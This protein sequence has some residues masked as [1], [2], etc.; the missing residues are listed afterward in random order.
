MELTSPVS[1]GSE[2]VSGTAVLGVVM[3]PTVR[4][5]GRMPA[6]RRHILLRG[7][8]KY[9][10]IIFGFDGGTES[11]SRA[12]GASRSGDCIP[13]MSRITVSARL[14][15][16]AWLPSSAAPLPQFGY[17]LLYVLFR[18]LPCL[19][20]RASS[21]LRAMS[22]CRHGGPQRRRGPCGRC[23]RA[24]PTGREVVRPGAEGLGL[25]QQH[26]MA[27]ERL[28]ESSAECHGIAFCAGAFAEIVVCRQNLPT[29]VGEGAHRLGVTPAEGVRRTSGA[30]R[31]SA[32][33]LPPHGPRPLRPGLCQGPNP[34]LSDMLSPVFPYAIGI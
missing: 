23:R 4:L 11:M 33:S 24:Q 5:R 14:S 27:C 20:A 3:A 7:G 34:V 32:L 1:P 17:R 25:F 13:A 28:Q 29:A 26:P 10:G 19:D 6:W 31:A 8:G 15:A 30:M 9:P 12:S 2:S 18:F 22:S 16:S 21:W